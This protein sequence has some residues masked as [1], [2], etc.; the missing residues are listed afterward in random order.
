MAFALR[1]E[2]SED[3]ECLAIMRAALHSITNF[4]FLWTQSQIRSRGAS[5]LAQALKVV[6]DIQER[7]KIK[8]VQTFLLFSQPRSTM[9]SN[10]YWS[11]ACELAVDMPLETL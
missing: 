3:D 4:Q 6:E 5:A 7:E 11:D 2:S 8:T 1:C 10:A 9:T